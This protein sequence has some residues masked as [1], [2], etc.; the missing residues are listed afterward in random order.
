MIRKKQSPIP[1]MLSVTF[2]LPASLWADRIVLVGDFN[3]W[4][5]AA[6]LLLQDRDGVWR[7]VLELPIGQRYEFSYL[8]DGCWST[9]LHADDCCH[10][11]HG[12]LNSVVFTDPPACRPDA[13]LGQ[14]MIHETAPYP[15]R[16][17]VWT[18]EPPN[19]QLVIHQITLAIPIVEGNEKN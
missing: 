15:P 19:A 7:T 6:T 18:D 14:G 13:D 11:I 16:R 3:N 9:D 17:E 2:E 12:S 1:N 5:P 8:I 4:D 10:N